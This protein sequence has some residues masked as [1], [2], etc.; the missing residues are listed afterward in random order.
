[1]DFLIDKVCNEH[2]DEY[3]QD[4]L[5]EPMKRA[6]MLKYRELIHETISEF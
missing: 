6:S 3:E 4:T 5:S 1:V 2:F